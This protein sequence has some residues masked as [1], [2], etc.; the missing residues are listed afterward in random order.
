MGSL[1]KAFIAFL[2]LFSTANAWSQSSCIGS[3]LNGTTVN[4]PCTATCTPI[5]FKVPH[6]KSSSDYTVKTIPY[7]PNA[8]VTS[9][10]NELSELYGDDEYSSEIDLP[11]SICFYGEIYNKAVV[12]S[13]GLI[14]F[15][16]TNARKFNAYNTGQTIP[17][18]GGTQGA[19]SGSAYYPKASVM[20]IYSDLDPRRNSLATASPAD[21]KIEWRIEGNAPCRKFIVSYFHVGVWNNN[22]CGLATP[23]TFQIVVYES[24]GIVEVIVEQKVCQPGGSGNKAILGIQNWERNKAIAAPGK[25]STIWNE[26]NTAYQFTPAGQS[27]FVKSELYTFSGTLLNTTTPADTSTTTPGML[28]IK[29]NNVCPTGDTTKYIVKTYF[30]D[31]TNAGSQ[32]LTDTVQVIKAS[33]NATATTTP[34]NC[35]GLGTITVTPPAIVN[36]PVF[37]KLDNLPLQTSNFFPNVTPGP[38]SILV[39]TAGGCTTLLQ[40]TVG[41]AA[42]LLGVA[43][44]TATSCSGA[45]NGKVVVT[46]QSGN[47][48]FEYR[49]GT[50]AWQASNVFL[51]LTPGTYTFFTKDASGCLSNAIDATIV[52]GPPVTGTIAKTDVVCFGEANGTATLTLSSNATAPFTFS[53][54]NFVTTQASPVF[55]GLAANTYTFYF[56]DGVGCNG[57]ATT[58]ITAPAQLTAAAPIVQGAL[59]NGASNGTIT[60][61]SSGGTGTIQYAWN[62]GAFGASNTINVAAGTHSVILKDANGCTLP[63]NNII[64]TEP[65]LLSATPALT[66]NATCDGGLDGRITVSPAGGTTPYQYAI[67]GGA[68]QASNVFLVAPGSYTV[69]IKDANGCTIT[70]TATVGLTNT[71]TYAPIA[72]KT[73][74]EGSSTVLTPV[75]NATQ[76]AWDGTAFPANTASQQSITVNP[77]QDSTRY[78]LTATLG[79]C[80]VKDTVYVNVNVAPIPNAGPDNEICFGKSDTLAAS[81]GTIYQWSP[82]TNLVSNNSLTG[83]I[84]TADPIVFKPE[85]TITYTLSVIDADG[86]PS[87]TTDDV[88]ITVTPPIVVRIAPVDTVG[89][90]GDQIQLAAFSA[91]TDYVWSLQNG[92]PTTALNNPN[93]KNPVLTVERDETYRV[94]ASTAGGC[95]GVGTVAIKAYKGPDIYVPDAFTPNRDGKND[96]LRPFPVGIQTLNYFRIF[97]RWGGMVYEYKGEKRGPVVF[98]ML[99]STIG[100]NGTI[101]GKE[102][103][104]GAYVWVAEGLTKENKKVF[105]KG[106]VT[107][108][109]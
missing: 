97:D 7:A 83:N 58:I 30:T 90:I 22:I 80:A 98:N 96:L 100:W 91:A 49:M 4:I 27:F 59:C 76:F 12:G 38:H 69:S 28:D 82:T 13:N 46:A 14:T 64:V 92:Q 63:V 77:V 31:C 50:G 86:C 48:P 61:T 21:R 108:I 60:I 43:T 109:R 79:R 29:F 101:G 66:Q 34:A 26:N 68:F 53:K 23:N 20:A 36:D 32:V 33:F 85:R 88:T 52:A 67:D 99:N 6:F 19:E 71:L 106:V 78:I 54:D 103:T 70:Q 107:L 41:N 35:I 5:T 104:T 87:L 84:G 18:A 9:G 51:N 94:V 3:T 47:P 15:D 25:N 105:R 8:Y 81:G 11:F 10:G 73:I 65:T 57:T 42:A 72:D 93:I 55:N 1:Y 39:F 56:K 40:V 102:L 44:P 95:A 74:C 24:T 75:T 17:Y 37:Y 45:I 2:F 16:H 62:G 89:F